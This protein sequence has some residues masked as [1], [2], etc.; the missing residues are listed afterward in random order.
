MTNEKANN[1]HINLFLNS[2]A[3][4]NTT[5]LGTYRQR[6][7]VSCLRQVY[8]RN[9][10]II[11]KR[12]VNDIH[13]IKRWKENNVTSKSIEKVLDW[14]ILVVSWERWAEDIHSEDSSL[15]MADSSLDYMSANIIYIILQNVLVILT[16]SGFLVN[17]TL[18]TDLKLIYKKLQTKFWLYF[19]S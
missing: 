4:T 11:L 6:N 3:N 1:I 5:N 12:S 18:G 13:H 19:D 14:V 15:N 17:R 2:L 9:T 7:Q 16:F 8:Y 10:K